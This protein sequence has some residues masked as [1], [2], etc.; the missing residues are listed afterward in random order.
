MMP[1]G[2][3][4][5]SRNINDLGKSG[6]DHSTRSLRFPGKVSHQ[7]A[8][9][10]VPARTPN[11]PATE[12][13]E[14]RPRRNR[15]S[16][17]RFP[18]GDGGYLQQRRAGIECNNDMRYRLSARRRNGG[19]SKSL[20]G[21]ARHTAGASNSES[22]EAVARFATGGNDSLLLVAETASSP[23]RLTEQWQPTSQCMCR[24]QARGRTTVRKTSIQCQKPNC[25]ARYVALLQNEAPPT[26]PLCIEC[27]T[28][29]PPTVEGEF[30][31]FAVSPSISASRTMQAAPDRTAAMPRSIA[32]LTSAR[33]ARMAPLLIVKSLQQSFKSRWPCYPP[34]R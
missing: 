26:A 2:G 22:T 33:A 19:Q 29:L 32:P 13:F 17:H 24:A 20:R 25:G 7:R 1:R 34:A 23:H 14:H 18:P 9:S 12:Y 11:A 8:D 5:Q 16:I 21:A 30:V 31:Y 3:L 27:N 4:N 10:Y 6:I 28:P 15:A